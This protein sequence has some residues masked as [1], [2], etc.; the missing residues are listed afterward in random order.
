M[1]PHSEH[2]VSPR[3]LLRSFWENRNLISQM[4]RRDV[5]GRYKGSMMGLGWSFFNPILMLMVYTFVFSVVFKARWGLEASEDNTDFA[6][7]LFVGLIIHT[8]FAEVLNR[9]PSLILGNANYVKK[10]IFPLEVLPVISMGAALFHFVVS[11]VVLLIAC[12]L[13]NGY[14]PWS[15]FCLPL[16]LM[17]FMLM[18]L[19]F[20]WF[21]AS[22]G[23]FLRDVGQTIGIITTVMLF[24]AP[25][26]YP[27]SALPEKYQ[28][29]LY[30]NPLTFIIEQARQVLIFGKLPSWS[31]LAIYAG[32]SFFVAWAG[33][34]WFQKTR[35]GFSDVI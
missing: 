18:T 13:L 12:V 24:L 32:I 14:L 1:N 8:L 2:L 31:G 35:K 23:V 15:S 16:I 30:L 17:P 20:A 4:T 33:Y 34:L 19:G 22:I 29:Y 21:L 6:I 27:I 28:A 25:V 10:V 11:L 26:F 3:S 7:I 5:V 9:A